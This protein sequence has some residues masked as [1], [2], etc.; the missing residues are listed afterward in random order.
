MEFLYYGG[1]F[2]F[3]EM[4]TRLQVEHPITELVTGLDIVKYMLKIASGEEL[5]LKQKDIRFYGHAIEFRIYAE[6]PIAFMPR[7]GKIEHYRSAGGIG[8]RVDSGIH[9]GV[10]ITPYYDPIIS[11]L[12]V[13]GVDRKEAIQRANRALYGY[14]ID[15]VETNIPF[16]I[17]VI[18]NEA[19]VR[20][21]THTNF[22]EEQNIREEIRRIQEEI[23]PLR[24]RLS[25]IFW[26]PRKEKVVLGQRRVEET[27]NVW[28]AQARKY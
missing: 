10:E 14:I 21:E 28:K 13:W 5:P 20:G 3:L 16:H 11:K 22:I 26:E 4:N 1:E 7:T 8:V 19:F 17:A 25:E 23:H 2:Y 9:Q 15:G 12:S 6:D 24:Q 27:I 18:N